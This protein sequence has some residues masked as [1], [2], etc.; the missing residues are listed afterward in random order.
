MTAPVYVAAAGTALPGP[1]VDNATLG[2]RLG[3]LPAW[4][5]S[6]IGTRTRHF[7]VDLTDG[8]IR[9]T[10]ADL[11]TAAARQAMDTAGIGPHEI[12]AVV[13]ATATPD[14][15]MP[16]TA[17]TVADRLGIDGVPGYQ[18]QSGCAGAVQ[19]LS[20]AAA[21]LGQTPPPP[22]RAPAVLVLG[23]DVC[24][25]HLD[26]G[27]P[28]HRLPPRALVNYALFGDGAGAAVL[29]GDPLGHAVELR[30][31]THR[32]HG[33]DREPGQIVEWFGSADRDRNAPGVSEDYKAVEEHV[34][35]MARAALTGLL[36]ATG[37]PPATVDFLLPPQL[38]GRMTAAIEAT[39]REAAGL[40]AD[41]TAV[42]CVTETGNTGN[43]LPFLQL[44]RLLPEMAPGDRAL[45]VAIESSKWIEAAFA[46]E[47]A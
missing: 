39:L 24:T 44:A 35:P 3:L 22:D 37:W 7:A 14:T 1:P 9:H 29:T 6:F 28:L 43:A 19:A 47:A 38:G 5:E 41:C 15:L 27:R 12:D 23:G 25:K 30:H 42:S 33:R 17:A 21:L 45:G 18:L 20:L 16:T 36:D 8:R 46:L 4:V 32:M 11:C 10:L 40:R 2:E 34:P 13:L 31:T 26:L